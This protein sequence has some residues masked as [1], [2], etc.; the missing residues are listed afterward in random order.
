MYGLGPDVV[1]KVMA[2]YESAPIDERLRAALA[3]LTKF[4]SPEED[5]TKDDIDKMR[6]AGLSDEEIKDVMYASF[7]FQCLSKWADAFGFPLQPPQESKAAA[8][9]LWKAPYKFSSVPPG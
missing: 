3:F 2:D 5:F 1:E 6:A 7:S 4:A 8:K 9:I